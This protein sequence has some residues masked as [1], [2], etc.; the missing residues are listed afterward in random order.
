MYCCDDARVSISIT[1][2]ANKSDLIY[3]EQHTCP[4]A[5]GEVQSYQTLGEHA[6]E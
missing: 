5:N 4:D 2:I 1:L 6:V 3:M